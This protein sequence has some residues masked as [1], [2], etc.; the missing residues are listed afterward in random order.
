MTLIEE[1]ATRLY[2][3]GLLTGS[4]NQIQELVDKFNE[5]EKER[6]KRAWIA[7]WQDSMIKPLDSIYYEPEAE[8]YYNETY[9]GNK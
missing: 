9:G 4:G 8:Q 6:I 7:A 3:G 2:E 5:M 1:F